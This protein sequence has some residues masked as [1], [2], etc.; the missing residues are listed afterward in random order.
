MVTSEGRYII[1]TTNQG[2]SWEDLPLP[3][4]GQYYNMYTNKNNHESKTV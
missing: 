1:K 4:G 3:N 2:N